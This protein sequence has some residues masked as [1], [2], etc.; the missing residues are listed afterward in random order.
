MIG[1]IGLSHLGLTYSLATAA[2]GFEVVAYDPDAGLVARLRAGDI[3][4]EEPGFRELFAECRGRIHYTSDRAVLAPCRLIFYALDVKTNARNES[5]LQPLAELISGTA[6]AVSPAATS[7]VMSQVPP[8]FMRRLVAEGDRDPATW[9]YQVETLVFGNAVARALAPERFIVGSARP[10]E[11]L[12]PGYREWLEAFP[13][14]ILPMRFESAE[15]AKIAINLYLVSAVSVTNTLAEACEAIGADWQEIAPALRLDRRIGPYAYLKPGLGLAGGNL[16]RDLV[17][18]K[19]LA[20]RGG[21]EAGI[22]EAWEANSAHAKTWALRTL[23]RVLLGESPAARLA[24][25]GLAYKQDTHSTRNS[26]SIELLRAIPGCQL[27]VYDP[28]ARPEGEGWERVTVAPNALAALAGADALVVMTP[29]PEFSQV[30]PAE[31]A[32]RMTG[33]LVVDPYGMI[34]APTCA[35]EGLKHF[36]IGRG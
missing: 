30:G 28:V 26:A 29:W 24:V 14:P 31:I 3:P 16:E 17:T 34:D 13:C 27:K 21:T 35:A 1:F 4:I 11:P 32:A 23:Q 20:A 25:W 5:D 6:A 18:I 36:Q 15:L 7:V 2:K 12:P 19:G 33:K 10:G 8:G 9:F 22:V